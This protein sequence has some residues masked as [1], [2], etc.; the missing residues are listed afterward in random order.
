V[1]KTLAAKE[2]RVKQKRK[3]EEGRKKK[4]VEY[5]VSVLKY[6]VLAS[7]SSGENKSNADDFSMPDIME[8]SPPKKPRDKTLL[9]LPLQLRLIKLKYQ[10]ERLQLF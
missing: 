10:T 7:S 4:E 8:K 3:G 6:V 2:D 1:D 5:I 9:H